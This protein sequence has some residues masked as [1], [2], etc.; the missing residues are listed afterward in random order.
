[1]LKYLKKMIRNIILDIK[2]M[3]VKS[4][5]QIT[6]YKNDKN[7]KNEKIECDNIFYISN[8]GQL[9]QIETLIEFEN[10]SNNVLIIGYTNKNLEMPSFVL[11]QV[12]KN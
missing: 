5:C 11:K 2:R 9:R 8:L 4:Q 6:Y 3:L 1:M 12:D 10:L 7:D